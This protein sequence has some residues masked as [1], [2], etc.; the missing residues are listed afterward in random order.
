MTNLTEKQTQAA[1]LAVKAIIKANLSIH[2]VVLTSSLP[3][4]RQD[5]IR[6]NLDAISHS[7]GKLFSIFG[8]K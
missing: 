8:R 1:L 3:R 6:E 2:Q 5:A 4:Y 7:T